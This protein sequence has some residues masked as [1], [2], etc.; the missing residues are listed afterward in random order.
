MSSITIEWI[1]IALFFAAFFAFTFGECYWLDRKNSSAI[2]RYFVFAF[3]SNIFSTSIGFFVSF[4]IFGI[5]LALAWDGSLQQ[6]PT[7]DAA[8]WLAVAVAALF[9]PIL[10]ILSKRLLFRLL[11]LTEVTRPWLY[12]LLSSILF[13]VVIISLPALFLYFAQR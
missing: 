13:F 8:I 6:L 12:S 1:T 3:V 5:L 11:K 7:G 2:G 4:V 10:L 9:P